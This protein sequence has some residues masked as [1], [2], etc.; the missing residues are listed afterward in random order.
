MGNSF[1]DAATPSNA[2]QLLTETSA[3][4][5]PVKQHL[6]ISR[7]LRGLP[8][9]TIRC[10]YPVGGS[11]RECYVCWCR[12]RVT[13]S[14]LTQFSRSPELSTGLCTQVH[15]VG[16]AGQTEPPPRCSTRN[17]SSPSSTA[18]RQNHPTR[19]SSLLTYA[20]P[21]ARGARRELRLR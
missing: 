21:T 4:F 11:W 17:L 18:P 20:P 9:L 2:V 12:F 7:P 19:P 13:L 6:A 15:Y 10:L 3:P 1:P 16:T 5:T 14:L 8:Q